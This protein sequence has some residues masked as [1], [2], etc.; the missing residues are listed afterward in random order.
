MKS[1]L[2]A[3]LCCCCAVS[4]FAQFARES[5]HT[6]VVLYNKRQSFD[7]YLRD[8]TIRDAFAS[9]LDS[10][11][12]DKYESACW[13]ICQFMIRNDEVKQGFDKL[14]AAYPT[15]AYSTR[16]AFLEAVYT[17]YPDSYTTAV[18]QLLQKETIPKLFA[19]QA[20][21]LF[22]NDA[23]MD[24]L[25]QLQT[26]LQQ[27][28]PRNDTLPLLQELK[29]YLTLH[30]TYAEQP[31]PPVGDL[32]AHQQVLGQKIIYSF[33]RWN[34]D[35]PGLAIVQYADGSFA[36]DSTGKLLVFQQ[37]A[38]AGSNLPYFITNG[39]TPQGIYSVQ[40][41]A[42]AHNNF[43]GPT[44]NLQMIMPCE[45]TDS[46]YWHTPYD[47]TQTPLS[48]YLQLLPASW[49]QYQP[50]T[51]AFYAG[52]TGRSEI[53]AHGTTIDPA[54]FKGM[55]F[56]PL[57]PTLG[58]LCAKEIWNE[59]NGGFQESDQFSLVNTFIAT[60]GDTGYLMVINIDNQQAPVTLAD[61]RQ[62]MK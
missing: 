32:F 22:R 16:R 37:L 35:Y 36:K 38:R 3:A 20:L 21:Y 46:A 30:N 19:M 57:T 52:K 10:N 48:N 17:V 59:F 34:R 56:Y 41:T 50:L 51:E 7:K 55:P 8:K 4:S 18:E 1:L 43:I 62:F 33:Q 42:I 54:Y 44:P 40:G 60:P 39:N 11:T 5:I 6:D 29:K 24:K 12:E 9:P 26:L 45:S 61:I 49:Q 28:F 27:K 47:S 31:T 53:I 23:S 13:A 2:F 15:L 14:F 25:I 58:C